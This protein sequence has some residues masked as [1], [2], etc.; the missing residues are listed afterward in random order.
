MKLGD[1]LKKGELLT[2][3]KSDHEDE[4][5]EIRKDGEKLTCTCVGFVT[6][7]KKPKSCKHIRQYILL[8]LLSAKK[9]SNTEKVI[10]IEKLYKKGV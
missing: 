8:E 3:W 9:I 5:Y 1:M 6:S 2:R 4:W 7:R 10:C